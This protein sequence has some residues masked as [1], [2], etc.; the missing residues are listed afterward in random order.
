M[1]SNPANAVALSAPFQKHPRSQTLPLSCTSHP[2]EQGG[3]VSQIS[4][5]VVVVGAGVAGGALAANLARNGLDVVVLE[6]KS[7]YV[8]VVRGEVLTPWGIAEANRMGLHESLL[9]GGLWTLRWWHQWDE[10]VA[11]EEAPA[12]DLQVFVVEGVEGPA[13]LS[14]DL[15]SKAFAAAAT[16]A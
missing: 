9:E 11:P 12:V 13:T 7:E 15:T 6:R 4:A 14:H 1:S 10:T 2:D 16:T 8:D 3:H 5:D